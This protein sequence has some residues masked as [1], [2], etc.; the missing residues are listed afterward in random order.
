[1]NFEKPYV[2]ITGLINPTEIEETINAF[3]NFGFFMDTNHIPM[4]GFLMS[5]RTLNDIPPKKLSTPNIKYLNWRLLKPRM[6][7]VNGQALNMIHYATKEMQSLSEQ[8]IKMFSELY[9]DNN[10]YETGICR[11]IQLNLKWPNPKSLE[12]ILKVLPEI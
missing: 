12:K 7:E 6:K 2:G 9:N 11:A 5:Y 10:L 1:M 4:I 3:H 8:V